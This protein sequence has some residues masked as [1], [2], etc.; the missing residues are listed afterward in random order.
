MPGRGYFSGDAHHAKSGTASPEL[1]KVD[2]QRHCISKSRLFALI[3]LAIAANLTTTTIHAQIVN[4]PPMPS[5][6]KVDDAGAGTVEK[7]F[8]YSGKLL[9]GVLLLAVE[10]QDN[11]F[12]QWESCRRIRSRESG[13]EHGYHLVSAQRR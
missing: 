5:W 10:F 7:H 6:I 2:R 3:T 9:K 8:D 1:G 4:R 12:G 11:A 13:E